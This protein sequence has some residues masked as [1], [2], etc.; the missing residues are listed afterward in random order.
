MRRAAIASNN[1]LGEQ[2]GERQFGK[3]LLVGGRCNLLET[4]VQTQYNLS[5]DYTLCNSYRKPIRTGDVFEEHSFY[6][7]LNT[8]SHENVLMIPQSRN[9]MSQESA[10]DSGGLLRG[11]LHSL[12]SPSIFC[13]RCSIYKDVTIISS[14]YFDCIT[15]DPSVPLYGGGR[16]HHWND[17]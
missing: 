6:R 11:L 5:G 12:R 3:A 2:T 10:R 1:L 8:A 17:C 16:H 15:S 4:L 13:A 9:V 7:D 14:I